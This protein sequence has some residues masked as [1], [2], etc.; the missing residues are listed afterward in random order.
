MLQ[1]PTVK[2]SGT[3]QCVSRVFCMSVLSVVS[4]ACSFVANRIAEVCFFAT[5]CNVEAPLS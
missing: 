5:S 2:I 4:E 1:L 3:N